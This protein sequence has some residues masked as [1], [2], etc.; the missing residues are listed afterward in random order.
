MRWYLLSLAIAL[1]AGCAK[2]PAGVR[3]PGSTA[4]QRQRD[5]DDFFVKWFKAHGHD[6]VVQDDKGVGIAGNETRLRAALY[7]SDQN[8]R[9]R[10]VTEVEFNVEL[11]SGRRILEFV[12]G[13]GDTQQQAI[14]EGLVN[15]TLTT[16]HVVYK[17]FI[18]PDDP[19]LKVTTVEINGAGREVIA[20]DILMQGSASEKQINLN[21]MRDEI[22]GALKSISLTP[23]PHWIKIVYSQ[24]DGNPMLVA[25]TMDNVDQAEMTEAVKRLN[26]PR[27]DGAYMAKQFIV[28]K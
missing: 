20:G 27:A 25:V 5:M 13:S 8:D 19:H 10:F 14:N 9:G 23:E 11:P 7:G 3:A 4:G 1:A 12:A 16:F 2:E 18:N 21:V 24:R 15:F 28:V 6:D 26:W 17:G 22:Q